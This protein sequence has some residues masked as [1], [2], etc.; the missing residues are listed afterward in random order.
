M[1]DIAAD[2]FM[3][4]D[5]VATRSLEYDAPA[6]LLR[7]LALYVELYPTAAEVDNDHIRD[8]LLHLV[9]ALPQLGQADGF[10]G[11]LAVG[12]QALEQVALE[13]CASAVWARREPALADPL[14]VIAVA[15]D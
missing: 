15:G 13:P 10:F 6:L 1:D 14:R 4:S 5:R 9:F 2:A 11:E 12:Q 7:M 3:L 8:R